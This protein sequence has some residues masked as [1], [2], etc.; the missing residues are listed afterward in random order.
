MSVPS[1]AGR[2]SVFYVNPVGEAIS[3]GTLARQGTSHLAGNLQGLAGASVDNIVSR[4][5]AGWTSA[6]Q[7]AGNGLRFFDEAGFERLRL[8]GPSARAPVGSNSQSG[9][10]LR[11]MDRAGNY[12][13]DAGRIVPYRATRTKQGRAAMRSTGC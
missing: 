7:R 10:T 6:P 5:P 1:T 12:Y 9:W 2:P 11:I 13:D 8:H 4:V 3:S